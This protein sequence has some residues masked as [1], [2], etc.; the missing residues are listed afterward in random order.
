MPSRGLHAVTAS[1][2]ICCNNQ[3]DTDDGKGLPEQNGERVVMFAMSVLILMNGDR[4]ATDS[5]GDLYQEC[6]QCG[7]RRVRTTT[8]GVAPESRTL[9]SRAANGLMPWALGRNLVLRRRRDQ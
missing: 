8:P 9:G 2:S 6:E 4:S 3:T 1:L 5:R 7:T